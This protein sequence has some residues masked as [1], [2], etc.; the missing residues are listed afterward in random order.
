MKVCGWGVSGGRLQDRPHRTHGHGGARVGLQHTVAS[1]RPTSSQTSTVSC[2]CSFPRNLPRSDPPAA[3]LTAGGASALHPAAS[4][5]A[6]SCAM[7]S[8]T[9]P[10]ACLTISF[11]RVHESVVRPLSSVSPAPNGP[12]NTLMR[13][14]SW[15]F[16]GFGA[17]AD[18]RAGA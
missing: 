10:M 1:E 2:T 16:W 12:P 11:L 9:T 4:H 18:G 8:R 14:I 17:R 5:A 7:C 3:L 15:G 13:R 6:T